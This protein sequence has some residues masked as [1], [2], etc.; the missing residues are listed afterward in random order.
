[1]SETNKKFIVLGFVLGLVVTVL[2]LEYYGYIRHSN[3]A[4]TALIDEFRLLDLSTQADIKVSE[5]DAGKIAF[6]AN[7]FLLLRPDNEKQVAGILVDRKNRP[8]K[9]EL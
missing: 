2:T 3:V 1:M 5:K 6:C 7:G 8:I 9:C 4:D